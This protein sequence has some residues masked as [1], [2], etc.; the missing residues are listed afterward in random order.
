MQKF[1]KCFT[2]L[3]K[4]HENKITDIRI[5]KKIFKKYMHMFIIEFPDQIDKKINNFILFENVRAELIKKFI[6]KASF[7]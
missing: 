2:V 5:I 4:Y 7:W 3:N 1:H 6:Q